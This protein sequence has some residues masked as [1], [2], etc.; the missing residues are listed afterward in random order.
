[1]L[2]D[3][4]DGLNSASGNNIASE[5]MEIFFKWSLTYEPIGPAN[6]LRPSLKISTEIRAKAE[7]HLRSKYAPGKYR[8]NKTCNDILQHQF[9]FYAAELNSL[10]PLVATTRWVGELLFQY[11]ESGLVSQDYKKNKLS[12][13]HHQRWMRI[14]ATYRQSLDFICEKLAAIGELD[15]VSS[16][17][18]TQI[19]DFEKVLVCAEKCIEYSNLSNYTYIVVSDATTIVIHE[20]GSNPYFEHKIN[21]KVDE[22]VNDYFRQNH[23]EITERK[24]YL[25]KDFDP[26]DHQ[27]HASI[28]NVPLREAFGVSYNEYQFLVTVA[29]ASFEPP[30]S[31][32]NM[33]M[34]LKEQ[35]IKEIAQNSN[36]SFSVVERVINSLILDTTIP[37]HVWN[38]RQHN[39]INKQPILEFMS[40]NRKVLM[41][42]NRKVGDF[43]TL[44]DSDLTFNKPP[45]TWT[46]PL[47]VSAVSEISD[48]AG[49][50]FERSVIQQVEKL[51]FRGCRIK[52]KTFDKFP[53]VAFDCG[54][55]DYLGYHPK[56]NCFAIFEFKMFETGFDARG[57]RQVKSSF[58]EGKKPYTNVF[59]KKINWIVNNIE[60][61][62][63]F[64]NEKCNVAIPTNTTLLHSAFITFYPTLMN[65]FF[66]DIPCKS[67]P[68]FI[69]DFKKEDKWPY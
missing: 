53:Q 5:Q 34:C 60:F 26:F 51:G 19:P 14:G 36:L 50:W 39:R 49:K 13:K 20:P 33:P 3:P 15:K 54:E 4:L 42:S 61:A 30:K 8:N 55:I 41:W 45:S 16:P 52:D 38:S 47:L 37:R 66:Q 46:H 57:I 7:A 24:K 65:L 63:T 12:K 27:Y 48:A 69:E 1:M 6:I 22:Q 2:H 31:Y 11:D 40:M 10:L 62:K 25:V 64:L 44:L 59:L 35:L 9:A 17:W 18:Q 28:L 58:M 43:L 56:T 32:K 68:Q 21:I 29:P 67:L 23:K